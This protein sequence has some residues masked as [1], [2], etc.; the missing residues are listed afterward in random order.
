MAARLLLPGIGGQYVS[1][2]FT[3]TVAGADTLDATRCAQL[4]VQII[5][6]SGTPAGTIQLT[7]SFDGTKFA[8]LGTAISVVTDGT[9]VVFDITDGPF[10][11]LQIQAAVSAGSIKVYIT[12]LPVQIIN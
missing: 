7:Q 9:I 5:K 1:E 11:M 3:T 12:G 4:A 10:G 8:N 6:T 2:V